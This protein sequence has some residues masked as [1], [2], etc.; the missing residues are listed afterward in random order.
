MKKSKHEYW[1]ALMGPFFAAW[2]HGAQV[3]FAIDLQNW[4]IHL[5]PVFF[6]NENMFTLSTSQIWNRREP[7]KLFSMCGLVV[8]QW[9][10]G[11]YIHF[12]GHKFELNIKF[13][14]HLHQ[15]LWFAMSKVKSSPASFCNLLTFTCSDIFLCTDMALIFC[16]YLPICSV[17]P[18]HL[19]DQWD[20]D[21]RQNKTNSKT[22]KL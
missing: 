6:T 1:R 20:F 2:L 10:L 17:L 3:T 22:N 15:M 11:R 9:W 13:I 4:Q 14:K 7:V 8:G 5:C 18:L 12:F 16:T 19:W 21:I